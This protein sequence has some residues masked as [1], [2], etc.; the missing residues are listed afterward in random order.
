MNFSTLPANIQRDVA[1][2]HQV[3]QFD[4]EKPHPSLSKPCSANHVEWN[5]WLPSLDEKIIENSESSSQIQLQEDQSKTENT[6]K[7]PPTSKT[8]MKPKHETIDY[9]NEAKT[10]HPNSQ[11]T[12]TKHQNK[13]K[14]QK[15][16]VPPT[17]RNPDRIV[18]R[19]TPT[20]SEV[21]P[22]LSTASSSSN[23]R[24]SSH[25][26]IPIMILPTI[27]HTPKQNSPSSPTDTAN[28]HP[29]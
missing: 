14:I 5:T 26:P 11:N 22:Q 21:N 8:S 1:P 18:K 9:Q 20:I 6:H 29:D 19:K 25:P 10:S 16:E 23:S 24:L 28:F 4:P 13:E 17:R 15:A 7:T 27:M 12:N 3:T 2:F